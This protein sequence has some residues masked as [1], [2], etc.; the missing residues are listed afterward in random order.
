[1]SAAAA[2]AV[3]QHLGFG[4]CPDC[5]TSAQQRCPDPWHHLACAVCRECESLWEY[6]EEHHQ[7]CPAA[8][9]ARLSTTCKTAAAQRDPRQVRERVQTALERKQQ[10]DDANGPDPADFS[11]CDYEDDT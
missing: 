9:I 2:A 4:A 6:R 3:V 7:E 1:M 8:A 11:P 10:F 5:P